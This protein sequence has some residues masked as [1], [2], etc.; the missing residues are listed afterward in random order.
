MLH[1]KQVF[2]EKHLLYYD[3][4][5][6]HQIGLDAETNDPQYEVVRTQA[7]IKVESKAHYCE[8]LRLLCVDVRWYDDQ[9]N[10]QK[11]RTTETIET[12]A[13]AIRRTIQYVDQIDM[14]AQQSIP[15]DLTDEQVIE[16][17]EIAIGRQNIELPF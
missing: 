14:L 13:L 17:Y 2:Y 7:S 15:R 6:C 10:L 16:D 12:E 1:M 9:D 8:E 5:A 3:T 11:Y 4:P